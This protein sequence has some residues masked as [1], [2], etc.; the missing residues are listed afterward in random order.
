MLEQQSNLKKKIF[1]VNP[2]KL[3]M[4]SAPPNWWW[5]SRLDK[6]LQN[7]FLKTIIKKFAID[8]LYYNGNWDLNATLFANTDWA[9]N[10]RSLMPDYNKDGYMR[11]ALVRLTV[12]GYL[13]SQPG[14]I[15]N[16]TYDVPSESPWE[17]GIDDVGESDPSVKELPHII[18]VST[19]TFTPIHNFVPRKQINE[20]SGSLGVKGGVSKFGKQRF[21]ALAAGAGSQDNN[22]DYVPTSITPTTIDS[23]L[24]R[25][26]FNSTNSENLA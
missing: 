9:K 7:K 19:F 20:Y 5:Y 15:T 21:I 12:G 16:L 10:I 1:W 11:G 6:H 14:F 8:K 24:Q 13:Y 22:Y 2:H 23:S 18:K 17:I 3:N 4:F 26:Q 25:N